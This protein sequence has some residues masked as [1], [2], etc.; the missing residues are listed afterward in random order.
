MSGGA[1]R[2]SSLVL[3]GAL[4]LALGVA[5]GADADPHQVHQGDITISSRIV[6]ASIAGSPNSAAYMVIANS[7][8]QAD[9]LVAA[10]CACAATVDIH[11]TENMRGMSMMVSA[12]P[13]VVPPHG[14]VVFQPGGYH[15]MLTGLKAPLRDG[16][17][18]A[19]TLVFKR[20]GAIQA[21]FR[22]S[23]QINPPTEGPMRGMMR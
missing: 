7:G 17:Q 21:S 1:Q 12:A 6:R 22:I 2:A 14:Q 15:V 8:S 9:A 18:Q 20:A 10:R 5:G 19:M 16:G 3:S 4:A 13:V 11:Q 23:A